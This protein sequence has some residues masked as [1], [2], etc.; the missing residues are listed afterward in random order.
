LKP[1]RGCNRALPCLVLFL[2]ET[3]RYYHP[4][5]AAT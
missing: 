5:L 4:L 1:T 2:H 3:A